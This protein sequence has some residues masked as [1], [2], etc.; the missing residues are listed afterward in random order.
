METATASTAPT[1][2]TSETGS[3]VVTGMNDE[4]FERE[5]LYQASME[6]FRAMLEQGLVTEEEY[7]VIDARMREKYSPVIGTLSPR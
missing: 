3:R 5:K 2:A 4:Q 7:A 6:M 1:P